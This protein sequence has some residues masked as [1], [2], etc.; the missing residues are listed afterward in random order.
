MA[1]HIIPTDADTAPQRQHRA[2]IIQQKQN[3]PMYHVIMH[4]DDITTMQFVTFVLMEVFGYTQQEAER[5]MMI[6]H[7]Q[8]DAV[9]G[10]YTRDIAMSKVALT[11]SIARDNNYPLQ[12]TIEEVV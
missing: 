11:Q 5:L 7:T 12:L 3:P 6:V 9:V 1:K 8:G 2:E 4:N 10:T